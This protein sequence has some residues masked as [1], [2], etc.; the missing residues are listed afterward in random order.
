MAHRIVVAN[1]KGGAGKS[2]L[3]AALA[4]AL[5]RLGFTVC[6]VDM[7]PQGN[8]TRRMGYDEEEWPV[9]QPVIADALRLKAQS[10]IP[11]TDAAVQ[12]AWEHELAGRITLIPSVPV[13][14]GT[15]GTVALEQRGKEGGMENSANFRL[16]RQLDK[17]DDDFDF[18]IIDVPPGLGHLTDM[19]LAAADMV[20]VVL[21]PEYDYVQGAVRM[22]TYVETERED[23]GRPDLYVVGLI[24][25]NV[26]DTATHRA[27]L[28]N[29]PQLFAEGMVWDPPI[30]HRATW[31]AANSDALPIE[32]VKG[33]QAAE[34]ARMFEAHARKLCSAVGAEPAEATA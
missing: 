11:I 15:S 17:F 26:Q 2:A 24:V 27:Q 12:C 20:L 4:A 30:P 29:L 5:A 22:V 25:T 9:G 13:R 28:A 7:D 18:T 32:L 21:Q 31:S 8:L 16:R 19:A 23:L 1:N 10:P 34:L 14:E 33:W 3:T 6:A